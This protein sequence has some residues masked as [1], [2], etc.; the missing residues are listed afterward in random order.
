[1]EQA[2]SCHLERWKRW[3]PRSFL[4]CY[5][6]KGIRLM[7]RLR[8]GL[9]HL[10]E[11]KFNSNFQNSINSL[12]SCGMDIELTSHFFT[13]SYL[14]ITESLWLQINRDEWIFFDRNAAVWQFIVWLEKVSLISNTFIDYIRFTKRFEKALL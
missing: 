9:S 13:V 10:R 1:M 7:T 14:M 6:H 11:Y 3:N 5:N 2:R 4:N 12:S 8:V